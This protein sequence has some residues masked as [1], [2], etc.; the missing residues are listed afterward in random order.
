MRRGARAAQARLLRLLPTE[1]ACGG[2]SLAHM[3]KPTA[4]EAKTGAW[5][6]GLAPNERV[7][8]LARRPSSVGGS[9]STRAAWRARGASAPAAPPPHRESE[10]GGHSLAH[11]RKP[12]ARKSK[13]SAFNHG[14]VPNRRALS[15]PRRPSSVEGSNSTHAAWR[16]RGASAPTAPPPH[17]ECVRWPLSCAHAQTDRARPRPA[18]GTTALHRTKESCRYR[19]L[20]ES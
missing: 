15:L 20:L 13:A 4:R 14:L 9:N 12:A 17:R 1:S 18:H 11:M 2:R 16:A 8:S 19:G 6:H 3:R 5:H 7:L 10:R